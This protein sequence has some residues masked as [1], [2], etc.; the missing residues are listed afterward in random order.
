MSKSSKSVFYFGIYMVFTGLPIF[1]I[2]NLL[3]EILEVPITTEPWIKVVGLLEMILGYY[4]ITSAKSV[5]KNMLIASTHGRI[6]VFVVFLV[7]VILK[8]APAV[9]LLFGT[10][11]LLGA[12]WTIYE[13]K[14]EN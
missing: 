10:A 8:I 7:F 1:F 4:Y 14:K 6:T 5:Y 11:D 9:V 3:L 13:L 2:P 12:I